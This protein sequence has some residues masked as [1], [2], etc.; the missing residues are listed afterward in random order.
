[1]K[2]TLATFLAVV[3]TS[4]ASL[5]ADERPGPAYPSMAEKGE[6]V[7]LGHIR[8]FVFD[9]KTTERVAFMTCK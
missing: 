5:A 4:L 6:S 1:M 3:C 2:T 7:G 9:Q 8:A